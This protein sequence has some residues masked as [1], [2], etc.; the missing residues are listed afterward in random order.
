MPETK[1]KLLLIEDNVD[2]AMLI[3]YDLE[4]AGYEVVVAYT[5]EDGLKKAEAQQPDLIIL[6]ISLPD[7]NGYEICVYIKTER[8]PLVPV[9]LLT[10]M[11][12]AMDEKLGYACKA[13]AYIRKPECSDRLLPEV[14]RLLKAS[15]AA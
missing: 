6:D 7:K 4:F 1:K 9:V 11:V 3:K 15:A 5:G 14:A 2:I 10:S 13:D 12:R 8:S